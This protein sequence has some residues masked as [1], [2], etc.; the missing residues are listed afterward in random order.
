[1]YIPLA[2]I[3][4][5]DDYRNHNIIW[6][7]KKALLNLIERNTGKGTQVDCISCFCNQE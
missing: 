7:N 3:A 6:D 2:L 1:M 4:N 5:S